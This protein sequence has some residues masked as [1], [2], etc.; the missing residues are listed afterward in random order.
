MIV[1]G[2]MGAPILLSAC[3]YAYLLLSGSV[4]QQ[5]LGH[6]IEIIKILVFFL[7]LCVE[8]GVF[9]PQK[10]ISRCILEVLR[11]VLDFLKD[12]KLAG[13]PKLISRGRNEKGSR[14]IDHFAIYEHLESNLDI[15]RRGYSRFNIIQLY[16]NI[17]ISVPELLN[18]K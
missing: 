11:G 8:I 7:K 4:T 1:I 16:F 2:V 6:L 10:L 18:H 3:F 5:I 14:I 15:R 17:Q 9:F 13:Y 12:V